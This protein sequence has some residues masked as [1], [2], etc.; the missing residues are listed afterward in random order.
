MPCRM[1]HVVLGH[2]DLEGRGT[3]LGETTVTITSQ[4]GVT[5]Q[6]TFNIR[7]NGCENLQSLSDF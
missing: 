5:S 3:T 7:E 2:V 1:A 4:H 6:N